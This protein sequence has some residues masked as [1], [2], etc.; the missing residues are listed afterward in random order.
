MSPPLRNLTAI[1]AKGLGLVLIAFVRLYQVC[2]SPLLPPACRF[3]PS[4]SQY[5]ILAVRKFGPVR[6]SWKGVC[7]VCRCHPWNP[8]GYDPP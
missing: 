4:C 2:L 3:Y 8:G 1:L 6:G 5:F 7:R